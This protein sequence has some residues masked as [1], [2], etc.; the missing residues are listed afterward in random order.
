MNTEIDQENDD[1]NL[2]NILVNDES[3]AKKSKAYNL[4]NVETFMKIKD[5]SMSNTFNTEKLAHFGSG[6]TGEYSSNKLKSSEG[7][8]GSLRNSTFNP[9]RKKVTVIQGDGSIKM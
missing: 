9:K 3:N 1:M 7:I 4:S 5:E 8:R 6:G 2:T